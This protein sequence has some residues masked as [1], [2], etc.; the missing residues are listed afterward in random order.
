MAECAVIRAPI[1]GGAPRP[2]GALTDDDWDAAWEQPMRQVIAALRDARA[3]GARRIVVVVPTSAMS[4]AAGY[5]AESATAEAIRVL[6]KSAA[7][8][9]GP[10]GITVNAVAVPP[11]EFGIDAG[12]VSLAPPARADADFGAVVDWL[13]SPAGSNVT[14]AT[15]TVDG[16]VWMTA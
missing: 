1:N 9:W 10:D 12:T 3:A 7:R 16:G 6:V 5:C 13:C 11:G 2:I 14:G 8:Q 15:I 4:G